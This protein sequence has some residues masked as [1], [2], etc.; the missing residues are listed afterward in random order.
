M[1]F[2]PRNSMDK[3]YYETVEH[4]TEYPVLVFLHEGLGCREMWQ[5]FPERLCQMTGCSG[6]LYDRIGHGKSSPLSSH[7]TIHYLHKH[8]MEEL[9]FVLE[10]I[11]PERPY[12]L[13]G[14]SDGGTIGLLHGAERPVHLKAII[15]EA[16]HVLVEPVTTAGIRDANGAFR[17]GMM[18]GLYTYHGDKTES[19]FMAWSDTWL[20]DWFQSWSIEYLLP[21][22]ICPILVMQ[23]QDDQYGT[24]RQVETIVTGVSGFAEPVFLEGCGHSPHRDQPEKVAQKM[25]VFIDQVISRLW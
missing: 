7:R 1:P 5:D 9:P 15:T 24:S 10:Q 8:A 6:L 19:I 16:A 14:H 22:I 4:N 21:S 11:I 12:I 17:K 25:S 13:V 20:S 3:I 2:L 23:G 18:D